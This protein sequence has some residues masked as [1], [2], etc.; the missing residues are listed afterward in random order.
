MKYPFTKIALLLLLVPAIS[1]GF[2][3]TPVLAKNE[4]KIVK[5]DSRIGMF[6][7]FANDGDRVSEIKPKTQSTAKDSIPPTP[8]KT[9]KTSKA[10]ELENSDRPSKVRK[11][12]PPVESESIERKSKS[13]KSNSNLGIEFTSF[14]SGEETIEPKLKSRPTATNTSPAEA[15]DRQPKTPAKIAMRSPSPYSGTYLRL[16][17]YSDRGKNDIGNPIYTLEAYVNGTFYRSFNAVSGTAYTQERDRHV[18]NNAAPLPDG[19]YRIAD[20]I[21]PGA[22]SEVGRTF[23][24][25]SPQFDTN[26]I[27]LGIHIDPSYN[28]RNGRDGTAGCIGLTNSEDR[29]AINAFIEEYHPRALYVKIAQ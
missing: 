6:S 28:Q 8:A 1:V 12:T 11:P 13:S 7:D 2:C 18:G 5:P 29:D 3:V 16:V 25:I 9:N 23:I 24:G 21:V 22:I 27:D 4:T 17:K 20:T 14:A 15:N 19:K 26:R 10:I